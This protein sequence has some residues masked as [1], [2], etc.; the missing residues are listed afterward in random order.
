[1]NKKI[2]ILATSDLHGYVYPYN[3]A[4]GKSANYGLARLKTLIDQIKDENTILIDNGDTI[5]G[6]P[7]T[8][9]HYS[10]NPDEINPFSL[11]MREFGYDY[12]N[13]GNH[14]FNYGEDAL[15]RHLNTVGG[16]CLTANVLYKG[17]PVG[18]DYDVKEILGKKLAFFGLC[19]HFVPTWED[20]N[21]IANFEFLDCFKEAERIVKKIKDEVNPDYIICTYHGGF[22]TDPV[23]NKSINED[24]GENQAYRMIKEID[25]IDIMIAGHQHSTSCGTFM[26][27]AYCQPAFNASLL[28]C[29]KIDIETDQITPELIEVNTEP[30]SHIMQMCQKHEDKVQKWLDTTLGH[31]NKDLRIH[32]E[33]TDRLFKSQ[34]ATFI[35]RV[36]FELTGADLSATAIFLRAK[37]FYQDITMRDVVSTYFFPNTLFIKKINGKALKDYLETNAR[38]WSIKDDKIIIDPLYDFP[39]PQHHNYDMVDGIE[40]TIK[41]SNP[42]GSRII[43][44]TRNG[45]DIKDGDEFTIVLNNYRAVGGGGFDMIKN[46]HTI[47]EIQRSAVEVIAEYIKKHHLI[48]FDDVCNIKV[49]K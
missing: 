41:V 19:T 8:F 30:D 10:N 33:V 27:C 4:N 18:P 9:F 12:T 1:M 46:A 45:K 39:T 25:G 3:Y 32:N 21:N 44:L 31:T 43:S 5:E 35:N 14:D 15:F 13:L 34:L 49:I 48:D 16:K 38:F 26:G 42:V 22:E 47:K 36:Q 17:K 28:G 23:T 24:S 2:T 29:F 7:F 40:Y 6:S 37:G 20:A 11:A